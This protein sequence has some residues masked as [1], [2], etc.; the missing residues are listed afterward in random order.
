MRMEIR[1][2]K[3]CGEEFSFDNT[4][5]YCCAA[6]VRRFRYGSLCPECQKD[7][8]GAWKRYVSN[9]DNLAIGDGEYVECVDPEV[10]DEQ[11]KKYEEEWKQNSSITIQ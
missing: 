7:E 10:W 6:I 1:K 5:R 8:D 11:L 9:L 2:C 4:R 3:S